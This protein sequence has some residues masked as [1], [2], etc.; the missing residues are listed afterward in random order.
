MASLTKILETKRKN[1]DK[2]AGRKRKRRQGKRST[3][4]S[5]ELFAGFGEPE[6]K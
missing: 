1:R 6:Q 2:K 4:S 5:E 3:T